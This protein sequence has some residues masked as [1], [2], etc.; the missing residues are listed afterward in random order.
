MHPEYGPARILLEGPLLADL[1]DFTVD[2]ERYTRLRTAED[3]QVHARHLHD[4]ILHPL[5]WSRERRV[6]GGTTRTFY[7][8]L[9]H[10]AASY[11][12]Q[13]HRDVLRR[14]VSWLLR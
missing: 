2:D 7:D 4:G 12:V 13:E 3:V 10:D 8:A 9:G 5:V 1:P 14:G 11:A 6:S